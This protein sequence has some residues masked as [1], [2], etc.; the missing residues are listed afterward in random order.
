MDDNNSSEIAKKAK[1]IA[2]EMT[3]IHDS[4]DDIERMLKILRHELEFRSENSESYDSESYSVLVL[5][6]YERPAKD[7]RGF[8]NNEI[9]DEFYFPMSDKNISRLIEMLLEE[10]QEIINEAIKTNRF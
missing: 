3:A 2:L 1:E 9:M 5:R 4:L 8:E 10:R 7:K 6:S